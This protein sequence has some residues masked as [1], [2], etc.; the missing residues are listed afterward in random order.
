MNGEERFEGMIDLLKLATATMKIMLKILD[1]LGPQVLVYFTYWK[2]FNALLPINT[3]LTLINSMAQTRL[4][5]AVVNGNRSYK[6]RLGLMEAIIGKEQMAAFW[7]YIYGSAIGKATYKQWAFV[8][9]LMATHAGW[10]LTM[11]SMLAA[12]GVFYIAMKA[13]NGL[14]DAL[15]ALA[16]V[17][18]VIAVWSQFK[19]TLTTLGKALG[20]WA[21]PAAIAAAVATIGAAV[22][23]RRVMRGTFG[24][25][26]ATGGGA[27]AGGLAE[28]KFNQQRSYDLGGVVAPVSYDTGG[29]STEHQTAVL[30]KGET[31]IPKTQN[32][33]SGGV[34]LNFGDVNAQDG[35]DFAEKVASALPDA[36]RRA[37]D[38]GA[39]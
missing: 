12:I 11:G 28:M 6:S 2:L 22:A 16:G 4:Q 3:I 8:S 27:A 5:L 32:M 20:P 23:L 7:S 9:S 26:A 15:A 10:K 13:S 39:I 37:N 25:N 17:L 34:T 14:G 36:L 29:M 18:V 38:Q 31:V 33:L 24:D 1:K 21:L 35:T 19:D 30:Q